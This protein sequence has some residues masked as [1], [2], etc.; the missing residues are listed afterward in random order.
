MATS[1]LDPDVLPTSDRQLNKG[2]DN[3]ALGPGD[4][5]DSG[6]DMTDLATEADSDS[7]GTGE[8]GS[9]ERGDRVRLREMPEAM[10]QV[11]GDNESG[12]DIVAD[13][14]IVAVD[15]QDLVQQGHSARQEKQTRRDHDLDEALEDTFPASD[16]VNL[17]SELPQKVAKVPSSR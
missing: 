14:D 7:N 17:T 13:D 15:E 5:S 2:H 12:E 1:T 3:H 6:S 8:R 10:E 9:V 4:S 11:A 16:P